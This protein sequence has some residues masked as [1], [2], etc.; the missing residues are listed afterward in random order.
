MQVFIQQMFGDP[1][2]MQKCQMCA[3]YV[4]GHM[5]STGN[6]QQVNGGCASGCKCMKSHI[7]L[8]NSQISDLANVFNPLSL[9]AN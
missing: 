3:S 8:L 5:S 4:W 2:I 1:S 6:P 7:Q 9:N